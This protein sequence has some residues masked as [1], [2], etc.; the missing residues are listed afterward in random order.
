LIGDRDLSTYLCRLQRHV[1]FDS[2]EILF[3]LPDQIDISTAS[4]PSEIAPE[5]CFHN[6][7]PAFNLQRFLNN[8]IIILM[9]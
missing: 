5:N 3:Q 7:H 1:D 4:N 8:R 6:S 9:D 2:L